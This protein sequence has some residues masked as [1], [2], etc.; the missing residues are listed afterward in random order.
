MLPGTARKPASRKRF[1]PQPSNFDAT[2]SHHTALPGPPGMTVMSLRRNDSSTAFLSHWLTCQVPFGP[3]SA[4]RASPRSSRSSAASTASRTGPLV[5]G[6]TSLRFSKASSM[7]RASSLCDMDTPLAPPLFADGTGRVNG[8]TSLWRT[9]LS[10]AAAPAL[11]S[12]LGPAAG[13]DIVRLRPLS[14]F[15][16]TLCVFVALTGHT[17]WAHHVMGGKLPGTLLEGTLAGFG[18]PVIGIDHLAAVV[19]VGCLAATHSLGPVLVIGYVL[20][21]VAGAALHVRGVNVPASELLVALSVIALGGTLMM[22]R[23]LAPALVLALF[24]LAGLFHGYALGESIVGAEPAPLAAYFVGFAVIQTVIALAALII[25]RLTLPAA[26]MAGHVNLRLIGAA[27]VGFGF[28][29]AM[30]QMFPA[31]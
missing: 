9:R 19:A 26:A 18:H 8:G 30:T 1:S 6:L 3:F 21:Q 4:T 24:L 16:T 22:R 23:M 17:A 25:V 2:L 5:A 10:I 11:H 13:E 14:L 31:A 7:V 27:L 20:A 15:G 12:A 28:A 29:A